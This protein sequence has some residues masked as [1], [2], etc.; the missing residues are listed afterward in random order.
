MKRV[1]RA[2]P[3][4]L[5]LIAPVST[6]SATSL[7]YYSRASTHELARITA[8]GSGNET[9][10]N[11][12]I[13]DVAYDPLTNFLYFVDGTAIRRLDTSQG[14]SVPVTIVSGLTNPQDLAID[15]VRGQLYVTDHTDDSIQRI[16][17]DSWSI[18]TIVEAVGPRPSDIAVDIGRERLFFT[19]HTNPNNCTNTGLGC[20]VVAWTGFEGGVRHE[21]FTENGI[22]DLSLDPFARRVYVTRSDIRSIVSFGFDGSAVAVVADTTARPLSIAV[23]A[24]NGDIFWSFAEGIRRRAIDDSGEGTVVIDGLEALSGTNGVNFIALDSPL[25]VAEPS[26]GLLLGCAAL[27]MTAAAPRSRKGS[28]SF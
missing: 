2:V 24:N 19:Y 12:D 8:T 6:A 21:L 18:T 22:S 17:L 26:A 16:D 1:L 28:S 4:F 27:A 15:P 3:L 7:V 23:D 9:L 25:A 20:R 11:G 14:G 5:A 10:L 13:R